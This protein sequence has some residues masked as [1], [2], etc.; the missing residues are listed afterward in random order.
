MMTV[1]RL[2]CKCRRKCRLGLLDKTVI[3]VGLGQVR[4]S[5]DRL[6]RLQA[7]EHLRKQRGLRSFP[8][9]RWQ[10]SL[11]VRMFC[12]TDDA[13]GLLD[14]IVDHRDDGVIR[15]TAL[16][17]T[18][19]VQHVAGPKPALLHALPRKTTSDHDARREIGH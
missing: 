2:P 9:L 18:I 4:K 6:G 12:V 17:R 1:A 11:F 8:P 7:V 10:F 15:D 16:A 5:G 19:V 3:L 14:P 13:A